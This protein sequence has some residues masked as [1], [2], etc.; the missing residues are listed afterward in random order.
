MQTMEKRMKK[1]KT[2]ISEDGPSYSFQGAL[3]GTG[4][5]LD[6]QSAFANPS[7]LKKLNALIGSVANN[8]HMLPEN[9][10]QR[11]RLHLSKVGLTFDAVPDIMEESGS[12]ELPLKLFGGRFGKDE[13]TP[14]DEFLEDDGL[15]H[16]IEGG[17]TLHIGYEMQEN[18]SC[19]LTASIK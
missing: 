4:E 9:A 15:E 5:T 7:V 6:N 1:F 13:N 2:F 12:F 19:R 18:N 8:N 17:L 3:T 10:I 16:H 14:H 11:I